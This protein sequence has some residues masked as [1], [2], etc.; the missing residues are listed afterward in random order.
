MEIME[1]GNLMDRVRI[2]LQ[3]DLAYY[4]AHQ[5]VLQENLCPGIVGGLL[6]F[7]HYASFAAV[8]LVLWWEEEYVAAFHCAS[9]LLERVSD[10][11]ME[12]LESEEVDRGCGGIAVTK[13]SAPTEFVS[14]V[15][16]SSS[17]L[18]E[19][20]HTLSQEALDHA[21]LTVLT[22]TLG[23]AA[24]IRN[25]LWCYN[26]KLKNKERTQSKQNVMLSLHGNYRQFHEMAEALAERL[27]DLHCRLL[28]LYVLQDADCLHWEDPHP[29]F[30]GERGSFVI[31]MWW[32]YMQGTKE[33]L[34][35]TV[36]P[37]MAQR[38]LAGMLNE[39]LTILAVRYTQALP[40]SGRSS[41]LV[42]DISNLLLC[43]RQILPSICNDA[44]ELMGCTSQNKVLHDVHAKC[45][46][47]LVCLILR[48]SPLSTLYKVF[49][50]GVNGVAIFSPCD[51]S[52]PAPWLVLTSHLF[53]DPRSNFGD[54]TDG[55][56]IAL[57]LSVLVAQPQASWPLLLKVLTMRHYRVTCVILQHLMQQC[58]NVT[59]QS[60][61]R[62]V[63]NAKK[64]EGEAEQ[65]GGFLCG[66]RGEC[67]LGCSP[68]ELHLPPSVI[69]SS[70]T[71]IT[72]MVGTQHDLAHVLVPVLEKNSDSW[73]SCLDRRQVWNQSRPPWLEAVMSPLELV[74]VPVVETL[75]SV[76]CAGDSYLDQ[77][78]DVALDCLI[79]LVDCLPTSVLQAA[80]VLEDAIPADVHPVSGSVLLQLVIAALYSQLLDAGG[81]ITTALAEALCSLDHSG[82]D[83]KIEAFIHA[84]VE[85]VQISCM[86][87]DCVSTEAAPYT[88]Q[89]LVSNLLLNAAGRRALKI[90]WQFMQHSWQWL[91][92]QLGALEPREVVSLAPP[93]IPATASRP[94]PTKLL[95]TMFHLGNRP[96]DQLLA[97]TWE[98]DWNK[99]LQ[100]PLSLTPERLWKQLSCRSEFHEAPSM[101]NEHD[102]AVISMLSELFQSV[103]AT[104]FCQRL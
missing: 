99:L 100:T 86:D 42:T 55:P 15:A 44:V 66:D 81:N 61:C 4:Q 7:P 16:D 46:E 28:S 36:P 97:G 85:C 37:K 41:L 96:F 76:G 19:H 70:L 18:L 40:S 50:R 74:L 57:E 45:H 63:N 51:S 31:Q 10:I 56:A 13:T 48:G 21:D 52:A 101:L 98:L 49:R 2:L 35:N 90:M 43:V 78:I 77:A 59:I 87:K 39:S 22:G 84:A 17:Q 91:L 11:P 72:T 24:L 83:S 82:H 95:H 38:V 53:P 94:A 89:I 33:D 54:L 12:Q 30:E 23:A 92:G 9:G 79:Q 60:A 1:E 8:K 68:S 80:A 62:I 29:F 14:L 103:A 58:A 34:W 25:C 75:L 71:Y 32:L 5:T 64:Q 93:P 102:A 88:A 73:A 6:D 47:L 67:S 69:V 65:C 3:R 20:L 104:P 26:E 27:L